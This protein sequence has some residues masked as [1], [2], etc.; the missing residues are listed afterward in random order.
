MQ[1][2]EIHQSQLWLSLLAIYPREK[3]IEATLAE[4]KRQRA[5]IERELGP[6]YLA[7]KA[8]EHEGDDRIPVDRLRSNSRKD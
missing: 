5:V 8:L 7:R 3:G 2:D 6:E 4:L 1:M